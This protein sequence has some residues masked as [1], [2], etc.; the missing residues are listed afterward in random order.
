VLSAF[1]IGFDIAAVVLFGA[2]ACLFTLHERIAGTR[3]RLAR[4]Q[5]RLVVV[6]ATVFAVVNGA[7]VAELLVEI[8]SGHRIAA[9]AGTPVLPGSGA[10]VLA[11]VLAWRYARWDA[12]RAF[13]AQLVRLTED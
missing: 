8:G 6:A 12:E 10:A 3:F 5:A 13:D 4:A 1:A 11:A 9:G 7:A 2:A